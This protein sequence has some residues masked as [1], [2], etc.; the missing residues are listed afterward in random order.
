MT[1]QGLGPFLEHLGVAATARRLDTAQAALERRR[2]EGGELTLEAIAPGEREDDWGGAFELEPTEGGLELAS[3]GRD[4]MRGGSGPDADLVRLIPSARK[5]EA[6]ALPAAVACEGKTSAMLKRSELDEALQ[7]LDVSA[8]TVRVT[9]AFK[10]GVPKG[11]R[12]T[13]LQPTS[14]LAHAGLCDGDVLN[15]V[16]GLPLVSPDK[17]LEI[18]SSIQNATRIEVQLTRAGEP[19]E[20]VVQLK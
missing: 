4:R 20:L 9:P 7:H 16:N 17:A 6:E 14:I 10:D 15:A 13:H 3:L 8:K 19:T 1:P 5:T 2:V 11:F 18:Y 12:L